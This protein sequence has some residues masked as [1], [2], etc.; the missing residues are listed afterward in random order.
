MLRD[1]NIKKLLDNNLGN[2]KLFLN[3]S[4]LDNLETQPKFN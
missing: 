2:H 4:K 1:R 3:F